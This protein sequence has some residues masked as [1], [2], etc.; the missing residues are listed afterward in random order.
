[1]SKII[2]WSA[3]RWQLAESEVE[4][5]KAQVEKYNKGHDY[6]LDINKDMSYSYTEHYLHTGL[7]KLAENEIMNNWDESEPIPYAF[8]AVFNVG[9]FYTDED[10]AI[11]LY[12]NFVFSTDCK[13]PGG[14]MLADSSGFYT[15]LDATPIKDENISVHGMLNCKLGKVLEDPNFQMDKNSTKIVLDK[16]INALDKN[17]KEYADTFRDKTI[18]W[19]NENVFTMDAFYAFETIPTTYSKEEIKVKFDTVLTELKEKYCDVD[20]S[21]RE[22]YDDNYIYMNYGNMI[23]LGYAEA[24][25]LALDGVASDYMIEDRINPNELRKDLIEN[26][27][28]V[29]DYFKRMEDT[30]V[31]ALEKEKTEEEIDR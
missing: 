25:L 6:T 3:D 28:S 8:K 29:Y 17:Y 13:E 20:K 1:M 12:Q 14:C 24:I 22:S 16:I 2:L 23:S 10:K 7:I 19:E 26:P 5:L 31:T 15:D 18:F 9:T 11:P 4:N 21:V 30:V 27:Q